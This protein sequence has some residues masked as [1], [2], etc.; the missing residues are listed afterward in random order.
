MSKFMATITLSIPGI[1]CGHCVRTIKT[2]L[3]DLVGVRSVEADAQSKQAVIN[4][5]EPASEEQ[6]RALLAEINYPA[7]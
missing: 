1:S 2:E 6:I 3:S 7:E 4:F 5:D